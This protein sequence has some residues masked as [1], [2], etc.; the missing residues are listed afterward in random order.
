MK[1]IF[2]TRW[3][4][5]LAAVVVISVV[6]VSFASGCSVGYVWHVGWGQLDIIRSTVPVER[7][8]SDPATGDDIKG[9]L[10]VI[11][12]AKQ[13]GEEVIGLKR[14]DS[15]TTYVALDRPVAAWNLMAAPKLRLE[16]VTWWFPIVGRMPYLG[17]FDK[18]KA[19][20]KEARLRRKGY[21]TYLRGAAAYSTL[22]WFTD[23]VFGPLLRY[24]IPTLVNV[25]IHEMT[26]TTVFLKGRVAYNEGMALFVGNRGSLDFLS[27]KYGPDSRYV[28]AERN[29]IHNDRVFS[30]FLQRLHDKLRKLYDSDLPDAEKLKER[31]KIFTQSKEEFRGL[32]FRGAAYGSFLERDLN[33]AAILSRSIYYV[34]LDMYRELYETLGGDLRKTMDFFKTLD[35]RKVD[36]PEAFTRRFIEENKKTQEN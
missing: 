7:V 17:Y 9:K 5:I 18:T 6:G 33:N 28:R 3:A 11:L 32:P 12:E 23:P 13:Y 25:T 20:K 19:I 22:G 31:E 24:D 29:N 1:R 30:A 2:T 34:D 10:R 14:T 27:A 26:H 35:K 8:M 21:D 4:R 36:D 16:P 15:Y